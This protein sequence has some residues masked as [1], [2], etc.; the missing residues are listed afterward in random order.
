[1][2]GY[3]GEC[4]YFI[5]C[6]KE[7]RKPDFVTPESSAAAVKLVEMTIEKATKI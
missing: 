6:I 2:D 3:A 5:D 1:M 4:R 7:D